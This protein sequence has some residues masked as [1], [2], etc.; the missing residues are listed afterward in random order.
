VLQPVRRVVTGRDADG[1]SVLLFDGAAPH[2]AENPNWPGAGLTVLWESRESPADN[3]GSA[4]PTDRPLGVHTPPSGTS[5][6]IWTRPPDS[7]LEAMSAEELERAAVPMIEGAASAAPDAESRV[8][9]AMHVTDTLDYMV[10]LSGELTLIVD[11]GETTLG[12]GD[13]VIDRGVRHSWANRGAEAAIAAI[14]TI[15]AL[16]W[17][18]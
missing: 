12:P 7:A 16:P 2:V 15:D 5:F 3:R 18:E 14:V 6:M 9:A 10:V 11:E 13:V 1:R 17:P 4:D 8:P